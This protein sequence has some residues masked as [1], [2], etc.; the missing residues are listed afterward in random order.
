M[1]IR[2]RL[3]SRLNRRRKLDIAI[4]GKDSRNNSKIKGGIC[5]W[6]R[7]DVDVETGALKLVDAEEK[8]EQ[9]QTDN[10][11]DLGVETLWKTKRHKGSVRAMCFDAKGD[12][13]FSVGSDN[14]LKKANTM[15]GKVVKKVNLSSLFNSEKKKNDKFTKLCISQTHPFVLIGDESGDIHVINSESLALTNSIRSIHFGDSI[16]DILHF[17]KLSLIHI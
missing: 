13:I 17:D 14:I 5:P 1:C 15:T 3:Q 12:S 10:N 2:D 8:H 11:E 4:T 9:E 16:N 6:T 7:L